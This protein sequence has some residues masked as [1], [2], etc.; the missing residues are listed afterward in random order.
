MMPTTDQ[1][2]LT[3]ASRNGIKA[4]SEVFDNGTTKLHWL[5]DKNAKQV[6]MY[7]PGMK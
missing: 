2:Y 4:E 1:N 5:G 3:F 7:C 6:I